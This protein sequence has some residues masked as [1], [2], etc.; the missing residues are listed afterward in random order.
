MSEYQS[1]EELQRAV[2]NSGDAFVNGTGT[3]AKKADE[4]EVAKLKKTLDKYI[5]KYGSTTEVRKMA[6]EK[7]KSADHML[8]VCADVAEILEKIKNELR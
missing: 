2:R 4:T 8:D 5:K 1:S 7:K 3:G 6:D